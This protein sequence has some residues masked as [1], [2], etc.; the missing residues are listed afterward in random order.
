MSTPVT[1]DPATAATTPA[2]A[3]E[4]PADVL[5]HLLTEARGEAAEN[6]V[7]VKT[8]AEEAKAEADKAIEAA[9][10]ELV[11][12]Y[13][14]KLAEAAT[15]AQTAQAEVVSTKL[16][17]AKLQA[18]LDAVVPDARERVVDIA[19][20]LIGSTDEELAADAARTAKLFGL[21]A[22]APAPRATDPSQGQG[23]NPLPLN[24]DPLLRALEG[25]VNKH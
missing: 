5:R 25:I 7:K 22:K 12:Q 15:T 18:A 13:E 24:G 17:A 1:P 3:Q 4:L 16:Q 10:A 9:K 19:K 21:D 2:P 11:T 20:R 23:G 8:V 6:R 14:A